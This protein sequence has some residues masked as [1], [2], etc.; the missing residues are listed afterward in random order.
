MISYS[1]DKCKKE[2]K[3]NSR[4][5]KYD[6]PAHI[7]RK[8]IAYKDSDGNA[9]SVELEHFELCGKCYNKVLNAAYKEFKAEL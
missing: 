2:I 7:T 3:E 6:F 8:G 9:C 1:C 5:F 4:V